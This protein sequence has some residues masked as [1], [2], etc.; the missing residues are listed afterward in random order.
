MLGSTPV[1]N[2]L[3]GTNVSDAVAHNIVI[4]GDPGLTVAQLRD[5]TLRMRVWVTETFGGT[6][7][8]LYEI[9]PPV[10]SYTL[11]GNLSLRQKALN[12]LYFY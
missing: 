8:N 1:G 10:V 6:I 7:V 11:A 4:S 3:T 9:N 2:T 12:L 5:P